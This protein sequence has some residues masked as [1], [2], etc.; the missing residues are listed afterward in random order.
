METKLSPVWKQAVSDLMSAGLNYGSSV[1]REEIAELCG[2]VEPKTIAEKERYDLKL[3]SC[4]CDIK[5]SLLLEH[6]MLLVTNRDGTYRVLH[7][8][9]Q[10]SHAVEEGTKAI[11]KELQR[12]A[13]GVQYVNVALLDD[14]QRRQ[15]ADAQAKLSMLAGMTK[16]QNMELRMIV[17]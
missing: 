7:P 16:M 2:L 12:M 5:E 13:T 6:E 3:M 4:I 1:S 9:E 14:T 17:E 15:N 8:K 11:A 10:T